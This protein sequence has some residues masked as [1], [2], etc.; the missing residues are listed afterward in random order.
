MGAATIV[1]AASV[2]AML[3]SFALPD[4]L[5]ADEANGVLSGKLVFLANHSQLAGYES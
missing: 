1:S 4:Q 2:V 5:A 3:F